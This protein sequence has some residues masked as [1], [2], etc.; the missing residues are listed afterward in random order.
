MVTCK[1]DFKMAFGRANEFLFLT[2]S[3]TSFP[4]SVVRFIKDHTDIQCRT[5][6]SAI[7]Y[8]IDIQAF[9]S[10]SAFMSEY[11][12]R[13]ILF[14][15]EKMPNSRNRFSIMHEFAHYHLE[16]RHDCKRELYDAQ[17]AEANAFAA[18]VLMPI[19]LLHEFVK[20]GRR[21][22]ES[23]LMDTFEVSKEAAQ[24]RIGQLGK[25]IDREFRWG[26][27]DYDDIIL[28]KFSSFLDSIAPQFNAHDWLEEE[29]EMQKERAS[30]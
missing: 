5:F 18:Q 8:G 17:E 2:E 28:H 26:Y 27:G 9:G 11:E 19:Q 12:G 30:W 7:R 15:N 21:T 1:P 10:T 6:K 16:H 13:H 3:I 14:F 25:G 22:D 23:F 29:L 4:F 20:R 24:I